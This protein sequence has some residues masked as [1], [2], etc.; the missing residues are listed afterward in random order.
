MTPAA[1]IVE[2]ARAMH[3]RREAMDP[4][5]LGKLIDEIEALRRKLDEA[6][7]LLHDVQAWVAAERRWAETPDLARWIDRG[8]QVADFLASI[9]GETEG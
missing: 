8:E 2:Q 4:M 5:I 6:V 3:E 7:N 1:D 9:R